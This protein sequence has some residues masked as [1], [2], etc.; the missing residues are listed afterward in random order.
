VSAERTVAPDAGCSERS[1]NVHSSK[2]RRFAALTCSK[3][4]YVGAS[5][6]DDFGKNDAHGAKA[7]LGLR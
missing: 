3:G 2:T 5:L 1:R 6:A 4:A 7:G